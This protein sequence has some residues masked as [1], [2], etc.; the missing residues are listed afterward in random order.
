MWTCPECGRSFKNEGQNHYCKTTYATIDEYIS[1]A[2]Q[3]RREILRKVRDTIKEN[4]PDAAEKISWQMPTFWQKEN[5]IHFAVSKNHLGVYPGENGITEFAER[6]EADG[7]KYSKGAVQFP[8]NR[9][10]P[11]ALIAEIT[12][13]RVAKVSGLA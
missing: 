12:K 5:L 9:E 1:Q 2:P 6:F 3:D 13:Y 4:A 11:Y 8:F 10:I 7:Y